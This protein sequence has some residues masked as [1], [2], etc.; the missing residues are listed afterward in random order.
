MVRILS[1]S[2]TTFVL[3]FVFVF[4]LFFDTTLV[5]SF[6]HYK[7]GLT[8]IALWFMVFL[9][10]PSNF[11]IELTVTDYLTETM[12]AEPFLSF[13]LSFITDIM[14]NV[15]RNGH[16]NDRHVN[17]RLCDAKATKA[18]NELKFITCCSH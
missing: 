14:I 2:D 3:L 13:K 4:V 7:L 8:V 18:F 10:T 6:S 12:E 16:E 5:F 15:D 9:H 1:E 11:M 17:R